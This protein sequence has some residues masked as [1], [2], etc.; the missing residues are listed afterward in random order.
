[1]VV[2][3]FFD[4]PFDEGT[5]TKLEIFEKYLDHWIPTFIK[6]KYKKPI[7]IFDFFAGIGYDRNRRQSNSNNKN[8]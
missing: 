4:E 6:G 7:Q 1:M 5:L 2:K 3:D 8:H